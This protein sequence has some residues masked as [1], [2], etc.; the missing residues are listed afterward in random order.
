MIEQ[1]RGA[2]S[3]CLVSGALDPSSRAAPI[4]GTLHLTLTSGDTTQPIGEDPAGT[5]R[6]IIQAVFAGSA[7]D[8]VPLREHSVGS[9]GPEP[10]TRNNRRREGLDL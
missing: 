1:F 8:S 5:C 7:G 9:S 6:R 10:P 4:H 3:V 2:V